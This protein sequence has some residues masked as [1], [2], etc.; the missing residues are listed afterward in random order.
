MGVRVE[1]TPEKIVWLSGEIAHHTA[2]QIREQVDNA[3]EML[4]PKRLCLDFGEVGFMDSSGI[5]LIMGR[6]RL[7]QLYGGDLEIINASERVRKVIQFAGLERLH[8]LKEK[9]DVNAGKS[10]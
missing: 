6:Y 7:I 4:K 1:N 9:E 2:R 5:G 3:V 8:V 10:R